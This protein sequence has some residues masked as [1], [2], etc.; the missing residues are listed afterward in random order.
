MLAQGLGI[1][2][3]MRIS[4]TLTHSQQFSASVAHRYW[5]E[6]WTEIENRR[7]YQKDAS[8][9]GLGSNLVVECALRGTS[10]YA[11]PRLQQVCLELKK[12]VDHQCLFR[13]HSLATGPSTLE[14]ITEY[15]ATECFSR[16]SPGDEGE[17]ESV[18]VR[19]N[20]HLSCVYKF[21]GLQMLEIQVLNLTLRLV[22]RMMQE[23]G[24]LFERAPVQQIVRQAF[25]TYGLKS[26]ND[27]ERWGQGLYDDLR[28]ALPQLH[29]LRIDLPSHEFL[30]LKERV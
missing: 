29:E 5:R 4:H 3:G 13:N 12:L 25:F 11:V 2:E 26:D 16:L 9:E 7:V 15:L 28:A 18:R 20:R 22:G 6:D 19:E 21:G 24:L 30:I 17:W 10:E 8:P 14:R 23:S 1:T 27:L